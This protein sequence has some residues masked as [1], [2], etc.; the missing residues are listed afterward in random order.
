MSDDVVDRRGGVSVDE[1]LVGNIDK[2][3]WTT[4]YK[5]QV[6]E[7]GDPARIVA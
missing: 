7:S 1:Q 3:Q 4:K 2:A 5:E 6:P